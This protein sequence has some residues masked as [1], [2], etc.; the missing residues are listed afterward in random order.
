M[1]AG[2]T[3]NIVND[4]LGQIKCSLKTPDARTPFEMM[5]IIESGI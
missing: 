1:V 4:S 3:I 5:E 2:D